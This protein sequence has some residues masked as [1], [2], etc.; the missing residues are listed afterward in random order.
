MSS[1]SLVATRRLLELV[2]DA[3]GFE[4]LD[5]FRSGILELLRR[6]VTTDYASYNEVGEAPDRIY[7]SSDPPL[8]EDQ[9]RRWARVAHENPLLVAMRATGDGRPKR[10]S[11][12]IDRSRFERLAIYRE[13]YR[14]LGVESQ[15]AFTLPARPPLVIALAL[16]RGPRDYDDEEMQLLTL[17]R[18]HLIQ[19]YRS[20]EL[21][22]AREATLIALEGGFETLGRH[23]VVLDSRG[24]VEF[25]TP[26]ARRLLGIDGSTRA[27]LAREL[28]EWIDAAR[29]VRGSAEP[30]VLRSSGANALVRL[31]PTR[32]RDGRD[33]LLLEGGSG[34]LTTDALRTLG[35]TER[36]SDALRRL[37]L[38]R[39]PAE[40]AGELGIAPRTF[41][42]HLQHIYAKLG[43]ASRQEAIATA[44]AAVGLGADGAPA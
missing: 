3:H 24:R 5:D 25:A 7:A 31:L 26:H 2:G 8:G 11:D 41:D 38:G 42:K 19:A 33:V 37:A 44:W 15:V 18:P 36:E 4:G 35:L 10:F 22:S 21:A 29:G 32:R 17:A 12:V 43:V 28:R 30:L 1:R 39:R 16:S 27:P 40:A 34:E 9:V 23:V 20:A 14:P 6:A 13:F